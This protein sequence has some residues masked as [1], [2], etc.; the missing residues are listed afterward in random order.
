MHTYLFIYILHTCRYRLYIDICKIIYV[1][2]N[3]KIYIYNWGG[4]KGCSGGL[5]EWCPLVNKMKSV[6]MLE[7]NYYPLSAIHRLFSRYLN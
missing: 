5:R 3:H 4:K 1:V 2:C 7:K 6:S